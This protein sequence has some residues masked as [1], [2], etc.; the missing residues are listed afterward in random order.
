MVKVDQE[1]LNRQ[2]KPLGYAC[3]L[4]F[5]ILLF[6]LVTGIIVSIVLMKKVSIVIGIIFLVAFLFIYY[7]KVFVHNNETKTQI[8][9]LSFNS[10]LL[11]DLF[12]FFL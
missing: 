3:L 7:E 12:F 5:F 2:F 10:N 8:L 11:N 1:R 9:H 6:I 4:V